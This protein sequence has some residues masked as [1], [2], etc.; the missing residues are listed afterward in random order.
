MQVV[1]CSLPPCFTYY[2]LTTL[3]CF[4]TQLETA[5]AQ[6]LDVPYL[7]FPS[8]SVAGREIAS[9]LLLSERVCVCVLHEKRVTRN[10]R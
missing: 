4:F 2:L 10:D 9:S 5:A 3:E 7:R 1:H 8:P 6:W